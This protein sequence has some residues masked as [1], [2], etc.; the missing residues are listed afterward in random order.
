MFNR[1][2]REYPWFLQLILFLLMLFT[3]AWLGAYIGG[4]SIV[5]IYG[6]ALSELQKINVTTATPFR[7]VA[8][9]KLFQGISHAFLFMLPCLVFAYLTHPRPGG[10]LGL[11]RPG[12]NLHIPLVILIIAGALPFLT[13][14]DGLL[15]QVNFGSTVKA[16][17]AKQDA[18]MEAMLTQHNSGDFL[19]TLVVMAILPAVGE[20]LLFRGI[21][22][23]FV[24]KRSRRMFFPLLVSGVA[25]A[26][27]HFNPYGLFSIFLAGIL[28]GV[29][30]WLTGSLWLS[31]LGHFLFNGTQVFLYFA[32]GQNA[33]LKAFLSGNQ[34]PAYLPITGGVLMALG[35]FLLWKTRRP[36]P[37]EWA[38]D[39]TAAEKAERNE[40][41]P[42][43]FL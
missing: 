28:M 3:L 10:Y 22:M 18:L 6:V 37:P 27:V 9:L 16:A 25:F 31:I 7:Q 33:A 26:V 21:I 36:L 43:S 42:F 4:I 19:I 20:E 8:A 40:Q 14:L 2:W 30:Y 38:E 17:Q 32:A 41:P 12:N 13:G 34:L 35:L 15:R 11:R 1:Y 29:I 23:R 5:K 24:A 39:F